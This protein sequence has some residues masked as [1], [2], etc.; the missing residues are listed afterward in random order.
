MPKK[1]K[2]G[3]KKGDDFDDDDQPKISS[4]NLEETESGQRSGSAATGKKDKKKEKRNK[5]GKRDDDSDDDIPDPIAAAMNKQDMVDEEEESGRTSSAKDSKKKAKKKKG[6]NKGRDD[7][8]DEEE[9]QLQNKMSQL[10]LQEEELDEEEEEEEEP[11]PVKGK[12]Q[13]P[14]KGGF[15]LL[16]EMDNDVEN[17]AEEDEDKEEDNGLPLEEEKLKPAPKTTSKQ[18]TPQAEQE[19]AAEEETETSSQGKGKK[20]KKKK[21]KKGRFAFLDEM[22]DEEE[23]EKKKKE[24]EEEKERVR[25][26][27]EAKEAEARRKREEIV[28]EEKSLQEGPED[29]VAAED[30][31]TEEKEEKKMS[32]KEMKKKKKRDQMR[33]Q[34]LEDGELSNFALSQQESNIKGAALENATDVK[35]DK[36]SISAA[37]KELFVNASLT[38]AQGRRYGLVG[39]NGMGKTTLLSHIA[40]R[41][42]AIPPNIDV[43]LC[44]QE[45]KADTTPAFLAVLN[46]DKKRLALLKEEKELLEESERGDNSRSE[47]LKE[48]YEEMEVIGVASAEARV[49]RILAGLQFTPDMQMKATQDFSGGWRMRVSLARALFM[50]PTL[51]LLDEPTNHLDLNAVIWLNNY[52]QSWKKT[53]LIVSHDQQFLDDVC[54]DIIHLDM[55]KLFYYKGNYNTFKKMLGQKRKEQLKEY[56]KQEKRIKSLKSQGKSKKAA[57]KETQSAQKKKNEKGKRKGDPT[58]EDMEPQELLKRPKEYVVKFTFPDPPPLNPPILGMYGV[59]FGYPG[60]KKLFINCDF[61]IDMSSRVAIVGPNGVGKSTFLKLLQGELSPLKGEIRKNHRLR[62]GSYSQHSA[63]QL[64]M[65][66]SPVEYLQT[67]YNLQYQDCRKLL[68]R[69]GLVSHAHTIKTKDLSG[70]QKSRVAFADLC[71]S[72]PD[73]VILD[74]PTNNLDIESIDALADAI[75]HYAGGV[76]IVSHDARLI[77]ETDCQLWVI[78]DQTINEIDGGFDDYK[79]ELLEELGE[80]MNKKE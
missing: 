62:I 46:A 60:Q 78:E 39:P 18:D 5:K 53:L 66:V 23:E 72:Q 37:G 71:Q 19:A 34:M 4:G 48:V 70:G 1:G 22:N 33:Q 3:G 45:V 2:K 47:R 17:D 52:L 64:T 44:E 54:T 67:K 42:L 36:F 61:G 10:A 26:E 51:L 20:D 41:K 30:Q 31:P 16:D 55:Q 76:I 73:I 38:V 49:R 65:D 57:E 35:V 63:D 21:P 24:E 59:D 29:A 8:D 15:A 43:L 12:K 9:Q 56:E 40:S 80:T 6:K 77:T 79:Q 7:S 27:K 58:E 50:E 69:F 11:K 68:G 75:N 74:E 28:E 13:Q 25:K 14:K 32:R